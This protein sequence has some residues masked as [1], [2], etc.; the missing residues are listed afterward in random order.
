M[1]NKGFFLTLIVIFTAICLYN[2][3]WTVTRINLD[4]ELNSY[5]SEE[6]S[7]W[8]QEEDNRSYYN[9]AVEN[10][11]SLGLD[12]QGGMFLTLE[13]GIDEVLTG[14]TDNPENP[15]FQQAL[16]KARERQKTEQDG[17][18]NLFVSSLKNID[19]NAKLVTFFAGTKLGLSYNATDD[20]VVQ[21]LNE[22]VEVA[23]DNSVQVL[24]TRIEQFGVA[25]PSIQAAAG[26]GRVLV[27]LPGVKDADRVRRLLRGTAELGFWPCY[28]G[29]EVF[30]KYLT[31]VNEKVR[32]L[33]GLAKD[34]T[35]TDSSAAP[36]DTA[37]GGD[38]I[39]NLIGGEGT[40]NDAAIAQAEGDTAQSF[41][42][43][44]GDSTSS[45]STAGL[46]EDEQ[47]KKFRRENPFFAKLLP[48]DQNALTR[49]TSP[50]VGYATPEDTAN[51]NAY[52][53][54]PEIR[55]LLPPDLKLLWTAKG[56]SDD[57][58]YLSLI[59]IRNTRD[60]KAPLTGDV[61]ID[62]RQDFDPDNNQPTV[63]MSMNVEGARTWKKMTEQYKGE[64][65]AV[66][67]DG[68]VYTYPTVNNVIAN[69]QSVISG[70]FTL[71]EATDLANIL[72]AGKLKAPVRIEGEEI[73]GPTLGLQT[74]QRGLVAFALGFVGII[75]FM[76]LYY[77]SSG[78]VASLALVANLV[79]I[80]GVSSALNIDLTLPGIAGIVLTLGMAVDANVLIY[81]R[82]REELENGR[83][84]RP[85]ITSGFKN[86]LS[87]IVDGNLTTLITGFILAAVG[88]GPIQ[89]FAVMLIIGI[90]TSM[91]SAIVITRLLIEWRVSKSDK[92]TLSFGI[93]G[94]THFFK[95][96][97]LN[98]VS[99]RRRNY[100]IAGGL[101]LVMIAAIVG[102]GF[103][104]GVD[105]RGGRQ[106]IVEFSQ[107]PT[108]LDQV[109]SDLKTTFAGQEPIVKT[110]GAKNQL[111]ITTAYLLD[112]PGSE[113]RVQEEL[114]KGLGV[115]HA[116]L[117]PK[118]VKSTTI[119]PTVARDIKESAILS[120]LLSLMAIFL[121]IFVRFRR[122]Q[123]GLGALISLAFNV[124]VV[125]G[126]F[127]LLGQLTLPFSVELDQ[128]FI[129]AILTIIG[130]TINDTVIVFDRIRETMHGT[131]ATDSLAPIFNQ[132]LNDTLSRTVI[133][134]FTT[135]ISALILFLFAGQVIQGFML[136]MILGIVIGTFSSLFVASPIA[137]DLLRRMVERSHTKLAG[138]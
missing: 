51:V 34:T 126:V 81:E 27:E 43:I 128:A 134:S 110:I 119:G 123:F 82:I 85:A 94:A 77:R 19:P 133:T 57:S 26:T 97:N 73:V 108:S 63:S 66:V 30:F 17:F 48:P 103:K 40:A 25:S 109:R 38:D 4:A 111:M 120:I 41:S 2:I 55:N 13:V 14:L 50:I 136:A 53:A 93:P 101:L 129:A 62:T 65:I 9:R 8:L 20:E 107:M 114:I 5:T 46:S 16:A 80:V 59:A 23:F 33:E 44:I 91:V 75:T 71:E 86:A 124:T 99:G 21:K 24:R 76:I 127:A 137:L 135:L 72:K 83:S 106:Y 60:G 78:V 113:D 36:Q 89:G 70:N 88:V 98:L 15:V 1:K 95:T 69:G 92:V 22:E 84:F 45:D 32:Q 67:L 122:W 49:S 54:R 104:L 42:D 116:S 61:I 138:A 112:E 87:A 115:S 31:Q 29:G 3:F 79:F 47:A 121:Y 12:L 68:R 39:T 18:V 90:L 118:I 132:A 35:Q 130:Y 56:E 37:K 52:L 125:L 64:S 102:I 96:R 11:L 117:S 131:K 6:R 74:T 7:E 10:S 100:G 58:P 105:F 28:R